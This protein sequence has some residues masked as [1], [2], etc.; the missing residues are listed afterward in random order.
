MSFKVLAE[1][2]FDLLQEIGHEGKNSNVWTADEKQFDAIIAVKKIQKKDFVDFNEYYLE[3]KKLYS[4]EHQNVVQVKYAC[5]DLENIYIAMPFYKNGSIKK[6]INSR[7]LTVREIIRYATQFLSGVHN[8]HVK[9][10][11]HFD[12]KPDNI[13]LSN[14]NEALISDFGLANRVD[15]FGFS[16]ISKAY[17][18]HLPP[19]YFTQS[20][21]TML[22]DIYNAGLTLYR[23]CN[24]ENFLNN[25]IS[26][27]TSD[28]EFKNAILAGSFPDR[29]AFLPH[30][31]KKLQKV[32]VKALNIEQ[33]LRHQ[34]VLELVNE[35]SVVDELLDWKYVETIT[36]KSWSKQYSD[37]IFVVNL[38]VS[39]GIGQITTRKTMLA[40]SNT[41]VVREHSCRNIELRKAEKTVQDILLKIEK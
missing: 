9:D 39:A 6:L 7:F 35:I 27:F 37:K 10:L 26:Q 41:T 40:S 24:G 12:I 14:N 28:E 16:N 33:G 4:S 11:I 36:E 32:I 21:H 2:K 15:S 19:E 17:Y 8:I 22:Y 34:S 18:K 5:E 38:V 1:L 13:L 20:A 30:I 3:A 23:M 25:Q 31:P 29:K